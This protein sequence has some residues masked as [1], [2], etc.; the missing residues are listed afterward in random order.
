MFMEQGGELMFL[1][2][3]IG[4]LMYGSD[5]DELSKRASQ[6]KPKRRRRR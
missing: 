3:F 1:F 2:K 6:Q 5:Y 4:W